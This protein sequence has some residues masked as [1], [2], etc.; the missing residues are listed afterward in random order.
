MNSDDAQNVLLNLD[1]FTFSQ[2]LKRCNREFL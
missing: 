2:S 1:D